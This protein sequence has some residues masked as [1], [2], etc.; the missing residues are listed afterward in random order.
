MKHYGTYKY[1]IGGTPVPLDTTVTYTWVPE[2][3]A[4]RDQPAEGGPEIESIK[5][6]VDLDFYELDDWSD[7]LKRQICDRI[8]KEHRE[9]AAA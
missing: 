4:T 2:T 8:R 3:S 7:E 5:I 6:C 9:D 1:W